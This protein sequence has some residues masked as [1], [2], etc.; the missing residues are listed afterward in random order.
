MV[1]KMGKKPRS[2]IV[3]GPQRP[4]TVGGK[5][6]LPEGRPLGLGSGPFGETQ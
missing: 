6:E 5:G 1:G 3:V 4:G 2:I